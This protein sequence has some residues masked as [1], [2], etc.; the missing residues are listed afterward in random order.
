MTLGGH[1][2]NGRVERADRVE[3]ISRKERKV[4]KEV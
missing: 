4:H 1:T 2:N 3:V